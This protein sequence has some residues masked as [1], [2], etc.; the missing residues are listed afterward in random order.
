M[1][2][3]APFFVDI[4]FFGVTVPRQKQGKNMSDT[5]HS[6]MTYLDWLNDVYARV[7]SYEQYRKNNGPLIDTNFG[8]KLSN[9]YEKL[10]KEIPFY[11]K[12]DDGYDLWCRHVQNEFTSALTSHIMFVAASMKI[13][14]VESNN[15]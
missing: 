10:V 4:C 7:T 5:S 11:I 14:K 15:K 9:V 13:K 2:C 3:V 8:Y 6:Y 12:F 1:G